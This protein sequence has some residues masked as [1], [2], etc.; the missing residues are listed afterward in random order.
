MPQINLDILDIIISYLQTPELVQLSTVCKLYRTLAR[1]KMLSVVVLDSDTKLSK[2]CA[3]VLAD[4][5]TRAPCIRSLSIPAYAFDWNVDEHIGIESLQVADISTGNLTS[6]T[7]VLMWCRGLTCLHMAYVANLIEAYPPFGHSIASL[8]SLKVL[9]IFEAKKSPLISQLLCDMQSR[10][11]TFRMY[12]NMDNR[13]RQDFPLRDPAAYPSTASIENLDLYWAV[14]PPSDA[15][16]SPWPSVRRFVSAYCRVVLDHMPAVLPNL[17]VCRLRDGT[18]EHRQRF[19]LWKSLGSLD[20]NCSLHQLRWNGCP[21]HRLFLDDC[22][23]NGSVPRVREVNSLLR[24]CQPLLLVLDNVQAQ[25]SLEFW[26]ML[27]TVVPDLRG[28]DCAIRSY[29]VFMHPGFL[30]SSVYWM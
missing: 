1:K 25:Q 14:F 13:S 2:F 22:F 23:Q 18:V 4:V 28:L 10:L 5:S 8:T 24:E 21:T 7:A 17:Q 16:Y 29:L 19:P 6:L 11:R 15:R 12:Y 26:R 3:F 27:R 20:T 30:V 9:D